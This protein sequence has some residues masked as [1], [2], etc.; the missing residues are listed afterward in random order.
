MAIAKLLSIGFLLALAGCESKPA[1][2]KSINRLNRP[3]NEE[4]KKAIAVLDFLQ[5]KKYTYVTR[6]SAIPTAAMSRLTALEKEKHTLN[7]CDAESGRPINLTDVRLF[8]SECTS[9]LNFALVGDSIC[10][11]SYVQ[12]GIG[13]YNVL[14]YL[15]YKG[16]LRYE[17]YSSMP[18]IVSIA[19]LDSFLQKQ[20]S[21]SKHPKLAEEDDYTMLT[22]PPPWPK[23]AD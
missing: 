11:L 18:D 4:A 3:M 16:A 22:P 17:S 15:T 1:R 23:K 5:A 9:K 13:R 6:V 12:G 10:L 8:E 20:I 21:V 2:Q 7:L 19:Q 14:Y